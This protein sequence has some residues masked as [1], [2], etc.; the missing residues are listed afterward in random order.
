[1]LRWSPKSAGLTN[2]KQIA[3]YVRAQRD[4]FHADLQRRE[5]VNL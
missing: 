1:M 4:V 5:M 2:Q 3:A